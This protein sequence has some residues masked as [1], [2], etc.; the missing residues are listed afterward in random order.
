[1]DLKKINSIHFTGIKGVGMTALALC[2]QDLGKKVSGSDT[3][4]IFPTDKV[5]KQRKLKPKVGFKESNLPK[6]LDFLIHTGAHGGSTNLEVITAQKRGIPTLNL[7]QGLKL[8]TK[9]K[10]V[11]AVAGVG[12]KSTTSSMLAV[13]LDS[14]GLLPSFSVGVGS[15]KNLDAPGRFSKKSKFFVVEADEYVADPTADK[16]PRFHYLDPSI[17]ILTNIE[18]D[19]P[20][21]YPTIE[22]IFAAYKIFI[23]NVPHNG[24]IIANIDNQGIKKFIKTIDK[25]VTTYGFSP[26]SDWQIT[27]THHADQKQFFNLKTKGIEWPQMVLNVPGAYNVLNATAAVIAAHQLGVKSDKIK[28]GL[29]KFQGSSRRFEFKGEV[30]GILLYDDYAHHP[31]EI[32]SLLKAAKNWLPDRRIIAVFQSH[33]FSRTKTLLQEFSKSFKHADTVLI[34]DIFSSARETDNLGLTGQIFADSVKKHHPKVKY[35]SG[36]SQ[37]IKHLVD[38]SLKGDAIFTIGAGNNFLWHQD[39]IKALKKR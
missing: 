9:D 28:A 37:T 30:K 10:Q 26:Q 39:I 17:A 35:C 8:F 7:A 20:D 11:I 13:L 36:K 22:D 5:L 2:A 25:P 33:T 19:H 38:H 18:H 24:A 14:A 27:K 1:M 12:G 31:I 21:V 3:D 16:T 32:A 34:N 4:E 23:S 6:K 15:I 29:K